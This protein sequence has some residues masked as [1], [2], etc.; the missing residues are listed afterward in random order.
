MRLMKVKLQGSAWAK[1][2]EVLNSPSIC[3]C[4]G[5]SQRGPDPGL[6]GIKLQSEELSGGLNKLHLY[7]SFP[8]SHITT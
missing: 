7:V 3:L 6:L 5:D 1:I 2:V 8:I 4:Q